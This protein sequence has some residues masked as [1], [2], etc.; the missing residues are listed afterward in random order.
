MPLFGIG[1]AS[2]SGPFFPP[3]I[4]KASLRDFPRSIPFMWGAFS[5]FLIVVD[6][7]ADPP[8]RNRRLPPGTP[9]SCY[10]ARCTLDLFSSP[11]SFLL[12]PK[13]KYLYI[14]SPHPPSNGR[15][16]RPLGF[17]L[18]SAPFSYTF[19]R[20]PFPFFSEEA[21]D[22]PSL[23]PLDK[24]INSG[25]LVLRSPNSACPLPIPAQPELWKRL[26]IPLYFL[27]NLEVF[28]QRRTPGNPLSSST[29]L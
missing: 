1:D 17:H 16:T 12:R 23:S 2:S 5:L 25:R 13:T 29:N 19:P 28:P 4:E 22:S 3:L 20:L 8:W 18:L 6:L 27:L 26:V 15:L 14:L 10:L 9:F 7:G 21:L 24:K 11:F